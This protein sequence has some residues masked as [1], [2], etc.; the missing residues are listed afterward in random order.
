V[1]FKIA[2]STQFLPSGVVDYP[3]SVS[4]GAAGVAVGRSGKD[5]DD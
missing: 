4:F 5:N 1:T 2:G 3:V